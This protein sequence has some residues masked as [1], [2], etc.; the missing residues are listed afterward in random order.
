MKGYLVAAALVVGLTSPVLAV[1]TFYIM[2]DNSM[3][4]QPKA[5]QIMT[6]KP[7]DAKYKMM[8]EYKSKADAKAAMKTERARISPEVEEMMHRLRH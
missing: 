7:T 4:G 5:C 3:K 2:F 1:E 6:A 8:G